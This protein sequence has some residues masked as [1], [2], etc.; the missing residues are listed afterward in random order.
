MSSNARTGIVTARVNNTGAT[1]DFRVT[2]PHLLATLTPG[3]AVYANFG[4]KQ[5]SLDGRTTCCAITR[6]PQ[7]SSPTAQRPAPAAPAP[8]PPTSPAPTRPAAPIGSPPSTAPSPHAPA[9]QF[10]LPDVAFA[11]PIPASRLS[12]A[13]LQA[14][15]MLARFQTQTVH[16]TVHGQ[17]LTHTMVRARGLN[18][19]EQVPGLPDGVRRLLEL[20]V[21]RIPLGEPDEYIIDPEAAQEWIK[22]HPVDTLLRPEDADKTTHS[23]CSKWTW[24]CVSEAYKHAEGEVERQRNQL[25]DQAQ[26]VWDHWSD[27]L[28]KDWNVASGC[29]ADHTLPMPQVPVQFEISPGMTVPFHES[30]QHTLSGGSASGRVDGSVTASFPMQADFQTS[31]TFFYIPCLPFVFRPRSLQADGTLTVGEAFNTSVTATGTFKQ[32]LAVPPTGVRIPLYV[33]PIMI[34]HVPVAEMD[35]S[36][37]LEGNVEVGGTGKAEG[38]LTVADPHTVRFAFECSGHGCNANTKGVPQ[39]ATAQESVDVRG[40]VYVKPAVFAA[41]QLDF[42]VNALSV[43]GGPQPFLLGSAVGCESANGTQATDGTTSGSENHVLAGDVDWGLDLRADAL[44]AGKEA[45][46]YVHAVTGH[47]DGHLWFQDLAPGGSTAFAPDVT[48]TAAAAGRPAAVA[49]RMPSCFPYTDRVRY[50]VQWTGQG[51]A[52][53]A[54]AVGS[55]CQLGA[56]DGWCWFDPRKALL[57]AVTWPQAGSYT[58]TVTAVADAHHRQYGAPPRQMSVHVPSP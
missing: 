25:I 30:G 1:F 27:E 28:T 20:H 13:A 4:A 34:G 2:N 45:A 48:A 31:A 51:S 14:S 43:R 21:R 47:T 17:A 26:K 54:P 52:A 57:L 9:Q 41:L 12:A 29:L 3:T 6:E 56:G 35:V 15:E 39:P 49:I 36:A 53:V 38:H 40:R 7:V 42:D 32:T 55:A 11:D 8:P 44:V 16:A 24:H 10:K 18:G 37:Y 19:I 46:Q 5:V 23:G 22:T 33:F 58:V 50:H